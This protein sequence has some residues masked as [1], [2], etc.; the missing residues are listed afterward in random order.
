[1]GTFKV[2]NSYTTQDGEGAVGVDYPFLKGAL[3]VEP[4]RETSLVFESLPESGAHIAETSVEWSIRQLSNHHAAQAP[5]QLA[6]ASGERPSNL[7]QSLTLRSLGRY[8]VSLQ[9]SYYSDADPTA[10]ARGNTTA[11]GKVSVRCFYVR[12]SLRRLSITERGAFFDAISTMYTT[13]SLEGRGT[14]GDNYVSLHDLVSDHLVGAGGRHNDQLHDGMGFLTQHA[15]LT[16]RFEVA[17][18]AV[19]PALAVP[20]WDY[21][22]DAYLAN[23]SA[24]PLEALWSQDVWGSEWFGSSRGVNHTI[25]EGRFAYLEIAKN[26]SAPV[27]SPYGYLRAP[28]NV[29]KSPYLT[30]V[31]TFCGASMSISG[32][33]SWP[34]CHSH[35][36]LTFTMTN[37]YDWVWDAAYDPHGPVHFMIGGYTH[38]GNLETRLPFFGT[39]SNA[40][41]TEPSEKMS[42]LYYKALGS[43]KEHLIDIPKNMWRNG[44]AEFPEFCSDDTPQADCHMLCEQPVSQKTFR[45]GLLGGTNGES[46]FGDWI[47][48]L[49][50]E[51][52]G[53]LLE[54]ICTTPFTPGD[55]MEASSPYDPSFWPIHPT[56]ERLL[57]WKR[58]IQPFTDA[59]WSIDQGTTEFCIYTS[60]DCKGHHSADLTL[61]PTTYENDQGDFVTTHLSNGEL[62]R[63]SNP[64]DDAEYR[65]PY[66]FD[67]FAWEHCE[68]QGFAF[69]TIGD[70]SRELPQ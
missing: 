65:L 33:N 37:W 53:Q 41:G 20:Y 67:N 14:Y 45:D 66:I 54:T 60:Y 27:H 62:L 46:Y 12:R 40:N 34:T 36:L 23:N 3:V 59:E 61:W 35:W 31:H 58:I 6:V 18:Q 55:Q 9:F 26:F 50:E 29:N 38:C 57:Q 15:A 30:R 7:R 19:D 24:T 42:G 17:I 10:A 2:S 70:A 44:F 47:E 28:W 13:Q 4:H 22:Y 48:D 8:E 69:R 1:M 5:P 51:V 64:T 68:E 21:T 43:F 63:Y 16:A 32:F 49:P 25:E 11:T 56:M 39:G 52:W